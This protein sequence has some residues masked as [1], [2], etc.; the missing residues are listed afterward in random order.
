[1]TTAAPTRLPGAYWRLWTASAISNVGDGVLTAALPILATRVTDHRLSIGLISTFFAI[2]WLLFALPA[3]A[4]IDRMDRRHVL[5]AA[6]LFRGVLVG[7]LALAAAFADVQIWMLWVL[8]FGLGVGEVFFDSTSQTILPAIVQGDQ[9]GRAN[10]LR[11][12]AE[13]TGNTFLGAPL[14]SIMFAAAVW[15][16]FGFDAATFV[17]AAILVATLRGRFRPTSVAPS[18]GWRADVGQ[19]FRWL[20]RSVLLRNLAIALGLTNLAFA[21]CESTFVLFATEE[22]GVSDTMF[23]VLIAAVGAG[24]VAAGVA[25]GWLVERVGRRFAILVAAFVPVLTM[26]AVGLVA[27]TW[28]VVLMLTVQ[29]VMI[30]VW[31]IIAVTLRQQMVPDHLF[32]R[33]NSVYRWFS[34]GAM[35]I[36]ALIGGLVAQRWGL[37]APYYVGAA[38][39]L[40][41]YVIIVVHLRE[42]AIKAGIRAN[43]R[44][45]RPDT[46]AD[47]TPP[48][49]GRDPL[50]DLLD[51]LL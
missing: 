18:R 36:G 23:G 40:V 10:G 32:G 39:M 22:L 38:T 45:T 33:V 9:L 26:L 27:V 31:S 42:S 19:G 21:M 4:V 29:A 37:R 43:T 17:V 28:W 46:S 16:P 48:G 25:G 20:W 1:V 14:G 50:D 13:I 6:D 35:P 12:S 8:A 2:P 24:S 47:D 15:L 44:P 3:G 51:P 7:G 30:T 11:Y 5:I 41:A 49:I 34:W